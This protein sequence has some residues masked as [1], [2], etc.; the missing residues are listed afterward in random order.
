MRFWEKS[1]DPEKE[2]LRKRPG[3]LNYSI[4][5]SNKPLPNL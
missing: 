1:K 2:N 3:S 5:H 4:Q